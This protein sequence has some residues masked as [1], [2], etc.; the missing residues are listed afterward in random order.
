M[1]TCLFAYDKVKR[2]QFYYLARI[3]VMTSQQPVNLNSLN[4]EVISLC[5]RMM[6]D[7]GKKAFE[8]L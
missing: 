1:K 4:D 6:A 3:T 2:R 7:G 5:S 8:H